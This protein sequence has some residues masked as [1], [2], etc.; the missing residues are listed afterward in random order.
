MQQ[1]TQ[2]ASLCLQLGGNNV[3]DRNGEILKNPLFQN[4]LGDTG[5]LPGLIVFAC[6]IDQQKQPDYVH[7]LHA[8]T[9]TSSGQLLEH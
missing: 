7:N 5:G 6:D 9:S 2:L 3:S 4:A 1:T 8:K